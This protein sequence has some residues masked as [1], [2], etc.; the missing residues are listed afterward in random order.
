MGNRSDHAIQQEI[1]GLFHRARFPLDV[2]VNGGRVRITGPVDSRNDYQAAIDLVRS[3]D[4]IAGIDDEIE[5]ET[6]APDSAFDEESAGQGF[7]FAE[8]PAVDEEAEIG[9][10]G[11]MVEDVGAG[12]DD[13]QEAIEEGEPYF[14]PTDPVVTPTDDEQ[15]LEIRGGWQDT[16][17]DELADDP[18][19]DSS[20]DEPTSPISGQR[21]DETIREDIVRELRQDAL[22]IDLDLDVEV[23]RGIAVLKGTVSSVDD[24]INA[25]EVARRVPGVRDVREETILAQ[26]C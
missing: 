18:Q 4:G 9:Y 26:S 13:V 6:S 25:E 3:V 11:D 22:T 21:D 23:L 20:E 15:E 14:P 10:A 8:N 12:T 24:A 19:L 5:V 7:E 1:E 17:M 16:S 2:D